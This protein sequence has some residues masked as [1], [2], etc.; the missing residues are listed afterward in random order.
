LPARTSP[1]ITPCHGSDVG[2]TGTGWA[3]NLTFD[4][5]FSA[6]NQPETTGTA[7]DR[8]QHL[9]DDV[10]IDG[11]SR[12]RLVGNNELDG[13]MVD[14]DYKGTVGHGP[15]GNSTRFSVSDG[16]SS[17]SRARASRDPNGSSPLSSRGSQ[18]TSAS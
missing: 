2:E 3:C 10:F 16:Q 12:T 4:D 1:D 13:P 7:G 14:P 6:A 18:Y 11:A 15:L 8:R 17:P 9:E 5:E